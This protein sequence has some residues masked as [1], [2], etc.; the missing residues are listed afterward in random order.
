MATTKELTEQV[1]ALEKRIAQL[2]TTNSRLTDEV[3]ILKHNYSNLVED[4]SK[5][6]EAVA[7]RF[8]KK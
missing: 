8:Q 4:V 2:S 7:K 3:A 6:F 5:R 1:I